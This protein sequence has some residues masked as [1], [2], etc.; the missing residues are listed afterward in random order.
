LEAADRLDVA[1]ARENNRDAN[2]RMQRAIASAHNNMHS[3]AGNKPMQSNAKLILAGN[4]K[5]IQSAGTCQSGCSGHG[6]CNDAT[7]KCECIASYTGALCDVMRCQD[8]CNGHGLCVRG[9][10]LCGPEHFGSSCASQR[11]PDDCSGHGYCFSGRCQCSGSYG[12]ENCLLQVFSDS[13]I[14]FRLTK[15]R[16]FLKGPPAKISSLRASTQAS[17]AGYSNTLRAFNNFGETS[18]LNVTG[19]S[20][21]NDGS[22][23][24]GTRSLQVGD[25]APLHVSVAKN[26]A[27]MSLVSLEVATGATRSNTSDN[28][29][30]RSQ[31]IGKRTSATP[32]TAAWLGLGSRARAAQDARTSWHGTQPMLETSADALWHVADPQ[33]TALD[34]NLQKADKSGGSLLTLLSIGSE[35]RATVTKPRLP[36]TSRTE[37]PL[38]EVM[39]TN[40]R[41]QAPKKL[42]TLLA[43]SSARPEVLNAGPE[44]PSVLSSDIDSLLHGV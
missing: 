21:I 41:H 16:P 18:R 14:R 6:T 34:K 19:R 43:L 13:V 7:G 44:N 17:A 25:P 30:G 26:T 2:R 38:K 28:A 8:D 42:V 23:A 9:S 29:T 40:N 31:T 15:N 35:R 1:A 36:G 10:C 3:V 20:T 39:D 4:S 22:D 32:L 37:H 24:M 27:N 5:D 33:Q 11:C 12:G